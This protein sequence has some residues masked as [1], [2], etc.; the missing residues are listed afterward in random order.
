MKKLVL[1]GLSLSISSLFGQ[2]TAKYYFNGNA[3]DVSGNK[4]HGDVHNCKL[5]KDRWGF[6]SSAYE[7]NGKNSYIKIDDINQK[8]GF[9][10]GEYTISFWFK[11]YQIMSSKDMT[12]IERG[13]SNK[14]NYN[15]TIENKKV[16]S[17]INTNRGIPELKSTTTLQPNQWYFI[18]I[19][20]S[21]K[22]IKESS[23]VC[24]S[25]AKK[26][27]LQLN[28]S[29]EA[30]NSETMWTTSNAPYWYGYDD[31]K[32]DIYIG[33]S[34][35]LDKPFYGIIDDI[36]FNTDDGDCTDKPTGNDSVI[37]NNIKYKYV[38]QCLE[39]KIIYDTITTKVPVYYNDTIHVTITDTL[40][41]YYDCP[42]F[43]T[44][45]DTVTVY[46]TVKVYLTKQNKDTIF[47][48]WKKGSGIEATASLNDITNYNVRIYPNP[49]TTSL[50]IECDQVTSGSYIKQV[51]L[52]TTNGQIVK[53]YNSSIE[54]KIKIDIKD[55]SSGV[56]YL[57]VIDSFN[58]K[59]TSIIVKQ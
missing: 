40:P 3:K 23:C 58:K 24:I 37:L 43:K 12:L 56:Y 25:F 7:F 28:C 11:P 16:N 33:I 31:K 52:Y 32:Y 27:T 46:D 13:D 54:S 35:D 19:K 29:E 10:K 2:T 50:N 6:D 20:L 53:V 21:A 5:V 41:Y 44:Y 8:L 45:W 18:K 57:T 1:I 14:Y 51:M 17:K 15:I 36:Q 42:I 59:H 39:K 48:N 38:E 9:Y 22:C 55:V 4:I 30:T 49:A 34:R 26:F 47:I